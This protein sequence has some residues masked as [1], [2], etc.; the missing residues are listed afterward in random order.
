MNIINKILFF[1]FLFFYFSS[2]GSPS[3]MRLKERYFNLSKKATQEEIQADAVS[4][5]IVLKW[6]GDNSESDRQIEH[7]RARV[8]E[9]AFLG[10]LEERRFEVTIPNQSEAVEGEL[11][12][13]ATNHRYKSKGEMKEIMRQ[14][15]IK[16]KRKEMFESHT[17]GLGGIKSEQLD[18][19]IVID[20]SSTMEREL[21]QLSTQLPSLLSYIKQTDWRIAMTVMDSSDSCIRRIIQKTDENIEDLFYQEIASLGTEGSET[22]KGIYM[23]TQALS[24]DNWVRK[25]SALVLLF[26]SDEGNCTKNGRECAIRPYGKID[27]FSKGLKKIGRDIKTTRIYGLFSHPS[28]KN[29]LAQ[30]NLPCQTAVENAPQYK[31]L[32]DRTSGISGSICHEDYSQ[33]L[34]NISKHISMKMFGNICLN[35]KAFSKE[36]ISIKIADKNIDSS[37]YN[38]D[39]ETDCLRFHKRRSDP[40]ATTISYKS[41]EN[42]LD[43]LSSIPAG[44]KNIKVLIDN[45][46]ISSERYRVGDP[47]LIFTE[48]PE[49]KEVIEVVYMITAPVLR[50]PYEYRAGQT[51]HIV[52]DEALEGEFTH[53]Y[54]DGELVFDKTLFKLGRVFYVIDP[55]QS[56]DDQESIKSIELPV[57]PISD[58][59]VLHVGENECRTENKLIRVEGREIYLKSCVTDPF[60]LEQ[61]EIQVSY[62]Y[63]PKMRFSHE[64]DEGFLKKP[65][66]Y[67]VWS[68]KIGDEFVEDYEINK[69]K[70]LLKDFVPSGAL[71]ISVSLLQDLEVFKFPKKSLY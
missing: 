31:E 55:D 5:S 36:S 8:G 1:I 69:N 60:D 52:K 61:Q 21:E 71:K 35:E 46:L 65:H 13:D 3:D 38:Y 16:L 68:V 50:Y 53:E 40:I 51:K 30:G 41:N 42:L 44:A 9:E 70:V 49:V 24:C 39:T 32:V 26:I 4:E 67:Q 17:L 34:K 7:M 58:S 27:Y 59:I 66:K 28:H 33:I 48:S 54:K 15:N 62:K 10:L 19:L 29:R 47:K 64:V 25:D 22:E 23:A 37:E 45:Q 63:F 57:K 11:I 12:V 56:P 20:N 2:C 18:L 14:K 6:K 43:K